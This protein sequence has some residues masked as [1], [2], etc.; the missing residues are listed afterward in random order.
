MND[1]ILD[2]ISAEKALNILRRLAYKDPVIAQQIEKEAR[3]L[4]KEVDIEEIYEDVFSVLDGI[5]VEELWDRSGP[6]RHG[7]SSPEDMAVEMI[8]EELEPYNKEVTKYL[9]LGMVKEAKFY[10]MGVLKGI[11]QFVQESKSAFKDWATD[12]PEE[13]FGDLLEEWKNRTKNK[14]D[15]NDMDKFIERE[16]TKWA[17]WASKI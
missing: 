10:C 6:S 2:K 7:Y 13:C 1:N 15:I 3:Q 12:I 14:N 5:D 8:E 16:C 17:E 9:E 11:Y 4:L